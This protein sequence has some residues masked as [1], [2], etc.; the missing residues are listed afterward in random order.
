MG[1]GE[2]SQE[3]EGRWCA[4][5][6]SWKKRGARTVDT[7]VRAPKLNAIVPGDAHS[8]IVNE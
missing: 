5:D 6:G 1:K 4:E 7:E 2:K 3:R 8:S